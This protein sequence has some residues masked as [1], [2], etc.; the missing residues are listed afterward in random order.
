MSWT[1][2][3]LEALLNRCADGIASEADEQQLGDLLRSNPEARRTFR[4]FMA[5]HS[6]LQ[7]NY[8]AAV[9]KERSSPTPLIVPVRVSRTRWFVAFAAGVAAASIMAIAV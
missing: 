9:S 6:V 4:E 2:E 8:V 3:E 7:W 1:D 5:L